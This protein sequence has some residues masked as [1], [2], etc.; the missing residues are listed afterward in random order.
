MSPVLI[1]VIVVVVVLVVGLL[2]PAASRRKRNKRIAKAQVQA[3]HD[4]VSH[5]RNQAR[6]AH[7]EAEIAEERAKRAAAEG[8]LNERKRA[9]A[10][11][12]SRATKVRPNE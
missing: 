1:V 3:K 11:K 7:A 6:D 9:S 2:I 10:N 8:D 12:S 4:D 5:H